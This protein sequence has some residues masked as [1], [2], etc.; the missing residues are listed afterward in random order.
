MSVTTT[1]QRL[2][3][4][5]DTRICRV[6]TVGVD[7]LKYLLVSSGCLSSRHVSIWVSPIKKEVYF[8]LNWTRLPL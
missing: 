2:E 8:G 6:T 1:M 7:A 3:T 4:R 5:G